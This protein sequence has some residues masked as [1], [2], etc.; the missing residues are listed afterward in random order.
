MA[1]RLSS[2]PAVDVL[3]SEV[4][5]MLIL[6]HRGASG[7]APENT[8]AAFELART[9]GT[10]GIETDVRLTAD[11]VLV[12]VHD[13]RV[14]RTT[15]GS[16]AVADLTWAELPRSTREAGSMAAV[17]GDGSCGWTGCLAGRSRPTRCRSGLTICL[18][19]K[20]PAAPE[21]CWRCSLTRPDGQRL[22]SALSFNWE[23]AVRPARRCRS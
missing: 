7:Y 12:L 13:D 22:I 10:R 21:A 11:G 8:S 3:A 18:E 4:L 1:A 23:T 6:A 9:M 16:G 20:A 2:M 5:L 19:V 15:D 14:D 17:R